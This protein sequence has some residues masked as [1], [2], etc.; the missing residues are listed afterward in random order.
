MSGD[1]LL[2]WMGSDDDTVVHCRSQ[3]A[4]ERLLV[5]IGERLT[6][7]KLQ[8]HPEKSKVVYCK[9]GNRR[10]AYPQEQFTF[11]GFTFRQRVAVG[12]RGTNLLGSCQPRVVRHWSACC[13]RSRIGSS[14]GN[15]APPLRS[16]QHGTIRSFVAGGT[17]TGA[18][19]RA[20]WTESSFRL[21]GNWRTG[22]GE[23]TGALQVMCEA[24][25]PGSTASRVVI[26]RC[27]FN[28]AGM[29]L[30]PPR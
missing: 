21:I 11:L 2:L 3:A 27:S 24:A 1:R 23:Y 15:Q 4:A 28:G 7:C 14:R 16:F 6:H 22:R 13:V 18:S 17:T 26:R 30:P 20:P 5:E 12:S 8:M 25:L 29:A 9:D 19:T 10:Q